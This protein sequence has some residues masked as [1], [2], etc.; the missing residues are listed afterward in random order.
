MVVMGEI[1]Q[2][3]EQIHDDVQTQ[4]ADETNEVRLEVV[5]D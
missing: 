3:G 5:K 4:E 2:V 1:V